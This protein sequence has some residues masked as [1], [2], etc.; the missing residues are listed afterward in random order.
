VD[1]LGKE[2]GEA[3]WQFIRRNFD[4]D[5]VAGYFAVNTVLS[6]WDGFFNNY[7]AYHDAA[8]TGKWMMFPWDQD[9]TWG[10]RGSEDGQVFY[11]M[12]LTFGMTGDEPPANG[13]FF[14]R[15]PGFFSGPLLANPGFRNVFLARTRQLLE[16]VYTEAVFGPILDRYEEQLVP[17]ARLRAQYH[18]EDPERAVAQLRADIAK[19]RE[20]L[21]KRREFLLAQPELRK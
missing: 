5:Q 8:G 17:E 3:Q 7:F 11:N 14:W 6:H 1:G 4:V 19:C 16:T 12:A 10:V 2:T 9:S 18:K 21:R 20:H 15:P 13:G